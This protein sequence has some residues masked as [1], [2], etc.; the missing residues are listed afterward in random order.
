M[1]TMSLALILT[2]IMIMILILILDTHIV[3]DMDHAQHPTYRGNLLA[4]KH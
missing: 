4:P 3:T 2:L 1:L